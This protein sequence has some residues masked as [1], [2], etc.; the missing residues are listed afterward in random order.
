M[1]C[2]GHSLLTPDPVRLGFFIHGVVTFQQR[3][4]GPRPPAW[5]RLAQRNAVIA[6]DCQM[7]GLSLRATA[8]VIYGEARAKEAWAGPS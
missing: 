7:A 1:R 6:W 3:G 8:S 2:K 5:T 4:Y